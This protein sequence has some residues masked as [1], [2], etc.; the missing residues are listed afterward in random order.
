M[1]LQEDLAVA[2]VV[3]AL[4]FGEVAALGGVSTSETW[5]HCSRMKESMNST[6]VRK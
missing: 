4:L 1:T 3:V 6:Q 5:L 2:L